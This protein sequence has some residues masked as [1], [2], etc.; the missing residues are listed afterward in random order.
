MAPCILNLGCRW[1]GGDIFTL[2]ILYAGKSFRV[3][4]DILLRLCK[5]APCVWFLEYQA[6]SIKRLKIPSQ[7][8]FILLLQ[9]ISRR[10]LRV[11][12]RHP[13][14]GSCV[15]FLVEKWDNNFEKFHLP[16]SNIMQ[17]VIH[18]HLSVESG[19]VTEDTVA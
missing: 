18:I 3:C 1:R 13:S 9:S 11:E 8:P 2:R 12:T 16:L 19:K 17:P 4:P 7:D 14:Q 5:N 6:P 10:F 15:G